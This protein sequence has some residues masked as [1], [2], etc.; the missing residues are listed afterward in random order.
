M[1]T[2]P[3]APPPDVAGSGHPDRWRILAILDLSLVLVVVAVSSLNVALPRLQSAL[4]ASA[5]DLQWIVDAYALVFAGLLLPAGALGDRFGRRGALLSGLVIFGGAAIVASLADDPA[6]LIATRAAMGVGAALIMPATLSIITTVFPVHERARAIAI[7]AGLAGAGGAIGPI[8]SGVL[9]ENFWWGSVFFVNVPLVAL[10]FV[11]VAVFVPTSRDIEEAALDPLGGLLSIVGLGGLVYAVIEGPEQGWTDPITIGAFVGATAAIVAWILWELHTDRPM[12]DPRLFAIRGFSVGS[13]VITMAFFA[14]FGMFFLLTQYLQFVQGH[15]ALGA[16]V[17]TLPMPI[18]L[19]LVAPRSPMV[20]GRF[21]PRRTMAAGLVSVAVGFVVL[22]TLAPDSH[23]ALLVAGL[24]PLAIGMGLL[25]P[26]ATTTIVSSLPPAKAGVGSAVNDTTRELGGAFGIAVLGSILSSGYRSE[27]EPV[28]SALPG[29]AGEVAEES[30]GGAVAVA[31]ELG[32]QGAG[33][34]EAAG[35]A[36]TDASSNAYL[37]SAVVLVLTAAS[38]WWFLAED[39]ATGDEPAG[40]TDV[41]HATID[42]LG[43]AE[44]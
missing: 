14:M 27:I 18:V 38:V 3:S 39:D 24:V 12:L 43:V 31:G 37:V 40:A 20:V 2:S 33:L 34:L 35:R 29:E 19:M 6:Q 8:L 15:S 28:A 25:M 22:A 23:Y 42:G 26:P 21:G 1:E 41:A 36:F 11:L 9:L 30:I 32:P 5:T 7:W 10:T 13:G 4:D 44:T 17:R 16:G